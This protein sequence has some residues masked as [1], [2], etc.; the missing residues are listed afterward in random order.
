MSLD[1]FFQLNE[2]VTLGSHKFGAD[3]IIAFAKN[4]IRNLSICRRRQR[5]ARYSARSAHPA[6]TRRPHG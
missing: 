2:T 6:G 5:R 1:D 4:S 3:E